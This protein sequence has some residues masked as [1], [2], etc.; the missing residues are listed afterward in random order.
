MPRTDADHSDYRHDRAGKPGSSKCAVAAIVVPLVGATLSF[1]LALP[2]KDGNWNVA[3]GMVVITGCI[4]SALAGGVLT[5][6]ALARRESPL[7]CLAGGT[8]S[9]LPVAYLVIGALS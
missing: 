6:V 4:A 8:V 3:F 5:V 7:L 2:L 9:A 1:A